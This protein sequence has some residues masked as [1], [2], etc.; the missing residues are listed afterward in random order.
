MKKMNVKSRN[1][2]PWFDAQLNSLSKYRDRMYHKAILEKQNASFLDFWAKYKLARNKF[3]K[4]FR[5]KK[6]LYY[7]KIIE[8]NSKSSKKLWKK[9]NPYVNQ[10]KNKFTSPSQII[11]DTNDKAA[12]A[13]GFSN[14]FSSILT[15]IVFLQLSICLSFVSNTFSSISILNKIYSP[16]NKFKFKPV[17]LKSVTTA[18]STMDPDSSP[19]STGIE[20]IVLKSCP[21][22]V[23]IALTSLFNLCIETNKIP[24]EWK[25]SILSPIHKGKGLKSSFEN[26]RPI[27]VL[28]PVSKVF[29]KL[30]A[31]QMYNYFESKKLIHPSQ[32]GFRRS[33]SCEN[34]LNTLVQGWKGE[35]E[36]SR[37]VI[38]VFLD[39][40][41]AFDTINHTLLLRKLKLYNFSDSST[42]LIEDY[43]TNRHARTK[44][45]GSISGEEPYNVGVPQGSVLGPLLFIIFMNDL[46]YLKLKSKSVLYADDTT[47]YFSS[48]NIDDLLATLSSDLVIIN[49]WLR[50]NHLLINLSKTHA[51]LFNYNLKNPLKSQTLSLNSGS[52]TI[53]FVKTTKLLGV[54]I[55]DQLKFDQHTISLCK[56][57]NSKT[58]QLYRSSYLFPISFRTTL[59]KTFILPKFDY[60]STLFLHLSKKDSARIEKTYAKSIYK[61]LSVRILNLDYHSQSKLLGPFRLLPLYYHYFLRYCKHISSLMG[62]NKSRA[63]LDLFRRNKNRTKTRVSGSYLVPRFRTNHMKYSFVTISSYLLNHF[64]SKKLDL[65][66]D[67]LTE[68]IGRDMATL[69]N[70]S[71]K[72][73]T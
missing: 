6:A 59:I 14:Y 16:R 18:F 22:D 50:H 55:D 7:K 43:L 60:C 71:L 11:N 1:L 56:A 10:D 20:S 65:S 67:R 34:A 21:R 58:M 53:P 27:S 12:I 52:D 17:T 39:L 48:T 41:K 57:T 13:N 15:N 37:F 44:Y 5:T 63:L 30:L 51:M 54:I 64:L 19:G 68:Y 73:W 42:S 32:F 24:D 45:L 49:D 70:A 23:L 28:S 61:L 9:L 4:L 33:L 3:S 8:H 46:S 36:E 25:I 35:L 72:Y 2:V 62:K 38:S 26:Y 69:F 66:M 40:S 47:I 31:D 29:E